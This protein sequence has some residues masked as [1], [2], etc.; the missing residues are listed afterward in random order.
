MKVLKLFLVLLNP[1]VRST[2]LLAV[3]GRG[4]RFGAGLDR[5]GMIWVEEIERWISV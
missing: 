3:C 5:Y 1:D 4:V 2:A